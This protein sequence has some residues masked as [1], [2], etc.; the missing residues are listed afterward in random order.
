MIDNTLAHFEMRSNVQNSEQ[1]LTGLLACQHLNI[2]N[3]WNYRN[4]RTISRAFFPIFRVC[5]LYNGAANLWILQ[6]KDESADFNSMGS[7]T[8]PR[9]ATSGGLQQETLEVVVG[10]ENAAAIVC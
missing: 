3:A 2:F 4:F 8:G 9:P 7:M 10:T 5:G 1:P 6:V